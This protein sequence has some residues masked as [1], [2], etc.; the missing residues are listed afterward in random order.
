MRYHARFASLITHHNF[1]RLKQYFNLG[2]STPFFQNHLQQQITSKNLV[3]QFSSSL[4]IQIAEGIKTLKGSGDHENAERV[5]LKALTKPKIQFDIQFLS[6]MATYFAERQRKDT[7]IQLAEEAVKRK[8]ADARFFTCIIPGIIQGREKD[9]GYIE[10]V[11][12]LFSSII[13]N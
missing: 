1:P 10:F 13:L 12:F 6:V 9:L 8:V 3:Q 7:V 4:T 5:F 11:F 2:S